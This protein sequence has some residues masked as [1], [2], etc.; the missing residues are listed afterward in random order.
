MYQGLVINDIVRHKRTS[1]DDIEKKMW[2][3]R[4]TSEVKD[5]VSVVDSVEVNW[6]EL[7]AKAIELATEA[8]TQSIKNKR[9]FALLEGYEKNNDAIALHVAENSANKVFSLK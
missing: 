8:T 1:S 3:R 2:R 9:A 5:D 7:L 4:F 6:V